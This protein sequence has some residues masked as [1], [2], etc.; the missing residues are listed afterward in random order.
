MRSCRHGRFLEKA[1]LLHEEFQKENP[2]VE[3]MTRHLYDLERLMDTDFGKAALADPRMYAEIVKHRS[4]FNTIRGV[5]Y[6]MHH[7]SR[8]DFIPP[9]KLAEVWRRDYERMQEYFIYG[10]SLPYDRLIA[11]MAEL[12]DRFRK[13]VMEDDFFS[14]S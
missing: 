2:R 7:P 12:R 13:V 9:E 6:R 3:R 14:E 8:I 4:I 1:F 10:D 11:R 5:D